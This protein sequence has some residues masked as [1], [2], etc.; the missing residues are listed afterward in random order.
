MPDAAPE[1][2]LS[3]ASVQRSAPTHAALVSPVF[4]SD[5]PLPSQLLGQPSA[6]PDASSSAFWLGPSDAQHTRSGALRVKIFAALGLVM[7]L[8]FAWL[9]RANAK[10]SAEGAARAQPSVSARPSEPR[11]SA[12]APALAS[13]APSA[14]PST[15]DTVAAPAPLAS[16]AVTADKDGKIAV[17]IH[18]RPAN[19]R[20]YYR[21]KDAGRPP[22]TVT[23]EPGKKRAFEVGAPG[24]QT[25]KVVVDG[26]K[27]EI[28]VGLRRLAGSP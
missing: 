27:S 3:P 20:I 16:N 19:G 14:S 10:R 25:R 8:S 5:P 28:S 21:G 17:V 23:I 18:V 11:V 24:Y 12:A 2:A 4:P 15:A 1:P 7:A 26:T 6:P 9:V 13:A 22:L